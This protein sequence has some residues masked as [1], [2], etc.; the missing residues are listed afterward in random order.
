LK[1]NESILVEK[2][3][4]KQQASTGN[5]GITPFTGRIKQGEQAGKSPAYSSDKWHCVGTQEAE[6]KEF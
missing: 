1:G 2:H 3:G 6:R 5:G 4:S